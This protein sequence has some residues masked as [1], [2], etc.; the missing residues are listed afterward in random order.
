MKKIALFVILLSVLNSYSQEKI[1]NNE[2]ILFADVIVGGGSEINGEGGLLLGGS[3]NYQHNKNLFTVRVQLYALNKIEPELVP[4]VVAFPVFIRNRSTEVGVLYGNRWIYD[5][6]S[7]SVSGG[8]STNTYTNRFVNDSGE[9]LGAIKPIEDKYI[10]FPLEVS[11]TLFKKRKKP[12]HLLR[13]IPVGRP[14]SFGHSVGIKLVG[15]ISKNSF[16]GIGITMGLG[17]H[18]KY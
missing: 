8:I 9:V 6:S 16:V 15:N 1:K 2:P 4:F 11:F 10:G 14:T 13:L 7:L 17:I 5:G 12:Y 3:L 18:K